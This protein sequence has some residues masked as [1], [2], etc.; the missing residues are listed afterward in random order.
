MEYGESS[1]QPLLAQE[2]PHLLAALA[3]TTTLMPDPK[4]Q[5]ALEVL[6]RHRALGV[7]QVAVLDASPG[8][9][10]YAVAMRL[11]DA[12]RHDLG[13]L[14]VLG[15]LLLAE[16]VLVA[17]RGVYPTTAVPSP[18]PC[19]MA[20]WLSL[21]RTRPV[22]RI[23]PEIRSRTRFRHLPWPGEVRLREAV[24]L[25]WC[26]GVFSHFRP[27]LAEGCVLAVARVVRPGGFLITDVGGGVQGQISGLRR[28]APSVYQA[29][30]TWRRP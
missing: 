13:T 16:D 18:V 1:F 20:S 15:L 7:R 22:V 19:W 24:D 29:P 2:L 5:T 30:H 12:W 3:P 17:R 11:A 4:A 21:H 9:E 23:T 26:W 8:L 25:V 14:T 27:E 10:T 6:L 28:L